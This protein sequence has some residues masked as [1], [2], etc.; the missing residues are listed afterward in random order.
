MQTMKSHEE[1]L[2]D[3]LEVESKSISKLIINEMWREKK[4]IFNSLEMETPN[5]YS[6]CK[7]ERE[8]K[9]EREHMT[10]IYHQEKIKNTNDKEQSQIADQIWHLG[11]NL[12]QSTLGNI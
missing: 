9:R 1:K 12:W 2:L 11:E 7:K 5:E 10:L 6:R 8:S 4:L 3:K